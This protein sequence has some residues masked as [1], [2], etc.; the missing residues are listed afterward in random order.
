MTKKLFTSII[1]LILTVFSGYS[2]LSNYDEQNG[3]SLF[4]SKLYSDALP[5]LQRSAKAGSLPA[6]DALGQ[7]YQNGWGVEKNVT[8]MM[9]MYSKAVARNY[10]PSMINLAFYYANNSNVAKGIELLE[11]ATDLGSLEACMY[12]YSYYQVR[13]LDKAIEYCRK[14]ISLGDQSALNDLG[15]WYY[16]MDD[17]GNARLNYMEARDKRVLNNDS[18]ARLAEIYA[19][20]RGVTKS[21]DLAYAL[22]NEL[23]KDKAPYDE[24]LY[25][26]IDKE[27]NKVVAPQYPGGGQALYAFL[28]KNVRK[29]SIAIPSAGYG[30]VVVE[31]TIS[32]LGKV[33]NAQYKKRV[34]V[35]VDEEV[36]RLVN[37]LGGWTP[38]TK[39]GKNVSTVAQ[40]SMTLFPSYSAEVKYLRVK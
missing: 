38:A 28:R 14:R 8:N 12:L 9:N 4:N 1:V 2:Q 30:N 29:P 7:M 21:L 5:F 34:N 37:L 39:G 32:P 25:A 23:K 24:T 31:F 19:Y 13:D 18:K 6:L 26:E 33:T 11:K 35:R 20:G 40:L 3:L 36:M 22:L 10:T 17:Y 16:A 27:V 15:D